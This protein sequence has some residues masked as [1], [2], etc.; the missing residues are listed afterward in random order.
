MFMNTSRRTLL[1][2]LTIATM[3]AATHAANAQRAI[4]LQSDGSGLTG[5]RTLIQRVMPISDDTVKSL[6]ERYEPDVL[7]DESDANVVTIV[8][9]NAGNYVRSSARHAK[10]M[11][12][13]AGHVV[14]INGDSGSVRML[15]IPRPGDDTSAPAVVGG[16]V[17]VS[18]FRRADGSGEPNIATAAGFSRDE[19]ETIA[20]KRYAAGTVAK[21]QLIVTVVRLK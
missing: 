19:V 4:I 20:T 14:A 2:I 13:D 18:T 12:L 3:G 5:A 8:L 21:S 16:A 9:D 15:A 11:Q 6:I 10:V 7:N 17:T 1:S